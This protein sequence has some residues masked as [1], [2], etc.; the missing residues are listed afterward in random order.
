MRE[1]ITL[2]LLC[3]GLL[4]SSYIHAQS[5]GKVRFSKRTDSS[6]DQFTNSPFSATQQFF[7][8]H[9]TEMVVF[10]PYF[11][12][13][14]P[15]FPWAKFYSDTYSIYNPSPTAAAHP[16]W[17]LKDAVGNNVYINW[18]CGGG[19]CPQFAADI[20]NPAFRAF[21]IQNAAQV[22]VHGYYGIF[23]D[24]VNLD[25]RFSD[26]NGNNVIP[27]DPNTHALMTASSWSS[28]FAQFMEQVR[29]TLTSIELTHNAIWYAGGDLR[30]ANP[31]V[32]RE[33]KSANFVNR[34]GGFTDAGLTGGT[35]P[36]S[37]NALLNYMDHVHSLGTS[38]I[39]DDFADTRAG[40]EY[41]LAG[42]YLIT[43][44]TDKISN[45]S[46]TP[47]NWWNGFDTDLGNAAGARYTWNNL[48]RRDFKNGM[49]LLNEPQAPTRTVTLPGAFKNLDGATVTTVTLT[50][51]Q[52]VI[53]LGAPQAASLPIS[54]PIRIHA[55]GDFYR[56]A[57]GSVWAADTAYSG[58][59]AW[60]NVVPVANTTSPA[61]YCTQRY[62]TS[63][64][65]HF[66]VPNGTRA[67][68]LKFAEIYFANAGQRRFNVAINGTT[69]LTNFD[70]VA[71]AG[72]APKAI[73][74]RFSSRVTNGSLD[75]TFTTGSAD[76]PEV[77]AIEVR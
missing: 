60:G 51:S 4:N 72:G 54:L 19:K 14:T 61:L 29:A 76:L 67:V 77:N 57:A 7:R 68:T 12:L 45:Q 16:E 44:G 3:L 64:S 25:F 2:L 43:N 70:I 21:W 53:L 31:A 73:D 30:D 26:Q 17:I 52:G 9:F 62:G 15:W 42:Y 10:S 39:I 74:K 24:D 63:F 58:G 66:S 20:S 50:A 75:I 23:L 46:M 11:D 22:L 6:F 32:I 38:V 8:D 69:V 34:E 28:Y 5:S 71:A 33:I 40:R 55:G 37:L 18:G 27:M 47:N 48:M 65:Y 49:V 41:A 1:K 36:W 59:A 13:R 56:D 35:G